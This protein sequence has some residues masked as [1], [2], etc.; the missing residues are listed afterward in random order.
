MRGVVAWCA[1]RLPDT[2]PFVVPG[3]VLGGGFLH[4]VRGRAWW[5]LMVFALIVVAVPLLAWPS[6]LT[7]A[8]E[9]LRGH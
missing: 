6:L 4:V 1:Y 3:A 5:G 7:G 8:F 2:L 9:D